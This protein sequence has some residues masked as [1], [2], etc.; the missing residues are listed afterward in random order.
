MVQNP[1]PLPS[2]AHSPKPMIPHP[3]AHPDEELLLDYAAGILAPAPALAIAT[4]LAFCPICNQNT[5]I[6]QHLAGAVLEQIDPVPLSHGALERLMDRLDQLSPL[7]HQGKGAASHKDSQAPA[8]PAPRLPLAPPPLPL[9]T[10]PTAQKD[11]VH[12]FA[13]PQPDLPPPLPHY[14]ALMAGHGAWRYGL[15]GL[16]YWPFSLSGGKVRLLHVKAGRA[17]PRHRHHG[18][19][20]TVI[21]A[22]GYHDTS[23]SYQ[24]G[25]FHYADSHLEHQPIAETTQDCLCL[26]VSEAP[27]HLTSLWGRWLNP[28]LQL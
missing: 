7:P 13:R 27:F 20:M 16:K 22:G 18:P 4:H 28:L 2:T 8:T 25:D 12:S 17:M 21:L 10:F 26:A 1:N 9:A 19:E 11:L 14:A 23:G 3:T 24:C 6:L 5:R 15:P